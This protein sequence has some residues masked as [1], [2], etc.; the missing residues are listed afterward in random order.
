VF[1]FAQN[2]N[3]YLCGRNEKGS[4][5]QGARKTKGSARREGQRYIPKNLVSESMFSEKI[6][7]KEEDRSE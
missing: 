3:I 5:L 6:I 2:L 1:G 7:Y 4:P